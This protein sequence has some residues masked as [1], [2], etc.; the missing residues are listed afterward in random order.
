MT[1]EAREEW[2]RVAYLTL[3]DVPE[4]L[5]VDAARAAR[6]SCKHPATIVPAIAAHVAERKA[7]RQ[8]VREIQ[9]LAGYAEIAGSTPRVVWRPTP[10]ELAQVK[11]EVQAAIGAN[12]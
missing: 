6:L 9:A 1:L 8:R 2:L 7:L 3:A 11:R 12:A 4:D 5:F 10:E